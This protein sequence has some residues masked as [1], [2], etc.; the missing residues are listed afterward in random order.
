MGATGAGGR[1]SNT[2]AT[3]PVGP[4]GATGATGD[5]GPT[6]A[7][8]DRGD[9]GLAS[10]TG[11]TGSIG[12]AGSETI[13]PYA[14]GIPL[15]LVST[16]IGG[17]ETLGVVGDG[18]GNTSTVI[19]FGGSIPFDPF[20][21]GFAYTIPKNG[22]ITSVYAN[23]TITSVTIL[24]SSTSIQIQLFAAPSGPSLTGP[25]FVPIAS[26][27]LDLIPPLTGIIAIGNTVSGSLTGLSQ[28]INAGT[29]LLMVVRV[30][31]TSL[32]A[33]VTGTLSAGVAII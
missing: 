2:G 10:N 23:F 30:I 9:A 14:S 19:L 32:A 3:G 16:N 33:T 13:I 21:I 5:L 11:A 7:T 20:L 29:Q 31:S 8:G 4:V 6:G 28:F 22:T 26:T 18:N 24:P 27:L 12:P 15:T 25:T 1:A 17:A